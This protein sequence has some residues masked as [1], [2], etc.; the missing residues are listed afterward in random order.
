M[1]ETHKATRARYLEDVERLKQRIDEQDIIIKSLTEEYEALRDDV[2]FPT[3][4]NI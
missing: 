2:D 1:K 3:R 4:Y